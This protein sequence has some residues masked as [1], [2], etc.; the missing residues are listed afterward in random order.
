M[1][2]ESSDGR[3]DD[4][5][6]YRR[7]AIGA[8]AHEIRT[9]LTS[10]RMVLELARKDPATGDVTLDAELASMLDTSIDDLQG[11]A[12]DLQEASRLERGRTRLQ[13]GPCDLAA[14]LA[15]A[16]ELAG[17]R[18][19][20]EGELPEGIA[21]PWDAPYLAR[22]LAGLAESTNRVGEGTGVVRFT[23]SATPAGVEISLVSGEPGGEPRDIAADCS[24]AFFRSRQ[25]V[26]SNG[27]ELRWQ[28]AERYFQAEIRLPRRREA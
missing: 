11:L 28:R 7:E 6:K 14:V 24:Y 20:L 4:H 25:F 3:F 18:I 27:G 23:T 10:I 5:E 12:D 26:L 9:P 19:R 17:P 21:G 13:A 16:A 8:F 2:R 15:A 22:A 1:P